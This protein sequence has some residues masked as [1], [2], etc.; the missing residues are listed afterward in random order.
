LERNSKTKDYR[1]AVRLLV[2]KQTYPFGEEL[3]EGHKDLSPPAEAV[4]ELGYIELGEEGWFDLD[5][6]YGA[7]QRE[8]NNE[9]DQIFREV[10]KITQADPALDVLKTTRGNPML[11]ETAL[12]L[13]KEKQLSLAG[14]TADMLVEARAER[15]I[16]AILSAA[17]GSLAS[18][19]NDALRV[20]ASCTL[21]GPNGS[22]P[23]LGAEH[24][25]NMLA[26]LRLCFNLKDREAH[27]CVRPQKV[28]DAFVRL[29]MRRYCN[30]PKRTPAEEND[31]VPIP[32]ID[33]P[34]AEGS[35]GLSTQ[36]E[37]VAQAWR[38]SPAGMLEAVRRAAGR[39][40]YLA[41]VLSEGP[42]SGVKIDRLGA[43]LAYSSATTVA[44]LDQPWPFS[45]AGAARNA[46]Y[47]LIAALGVPG[48]KCASGEERH[49]TRRAYGARQ[50]VPA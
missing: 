16:K 42:P 39:G 20:I 37:L 8:R 29:V 6:L 2:V 22:G 35:L 26:V 25:E 47:R 50:E 32:L 23:E 5:D 21:A 40:D 48:L 33:V 13:L 34:L 10:L 17:Q 18:L 19:Q 11:V 45:H 9:N 46:A 3:P 27:P 41:W 31:A 44:E 30:A 7:T 1:Y 15:V 4:E 24:W 28:G 49:W 12:Q 36:R 14:M 43:A 38:M